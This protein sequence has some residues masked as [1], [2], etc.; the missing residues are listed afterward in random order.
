MPVTSNAFVVSI[1]IVSLIIPLLIILSNKNCHFAALTKFCRLHSARYGFD[2]A[3]APVSPPMSFQKSAGQ[4][5]GSISARLTARLAALPSLRRPNRATRSAHPEAAS[6][7]RQ[8]AEDR[9]KDFRADWI[10]P[11]PKKLCA[12]TIQGDPS[13]LSILRTAGSSFSEQKGRF[14]HRVA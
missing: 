14:R 13:G 6:F 8:K 5:H 1:I 4:T 7:R 10:F 3:G 2:S 9:S 12:G 11:H